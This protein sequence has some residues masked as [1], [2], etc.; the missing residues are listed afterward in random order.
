[1]NS[2]IENIKG[3]LP[4]LAVVAALG[5]FYYTTQHRLDH[6]EGEMEELAAGV[7]QLSESMEQISRQ[8]NKLQRKADR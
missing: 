6:L 8:V 1:M 7:L 2:M 3:L 4:L 5:G